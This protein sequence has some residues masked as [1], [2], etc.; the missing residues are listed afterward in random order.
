MRPL[1]AARS[2]PKP[3]SP[4]VRDEGEYESVT[5]DLADSIALSK[6]LGQ[7]WVGP[8][9]VGK[10]EM[11]SHYNISS[12]VRAIPRSLKSERLYQSYGQVQSS[13]RV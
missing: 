5:T 2:A 10:S 3:I 9:T 1:L 4:Q 13:S 6:A 12:P 11:P 7:K 8:L